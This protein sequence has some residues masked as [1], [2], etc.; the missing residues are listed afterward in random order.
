MGL[1]MFSQI[2]HGS[3][4]CSYPFP[5]MHYFMGGWGGGRGDEGGGGR[6]EKE[7]E[8]EICN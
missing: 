1:H 2:S 6:E 5:L 7:E 4:V 3:E 8:E